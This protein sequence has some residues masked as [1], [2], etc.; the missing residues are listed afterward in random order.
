MARPVDPGRVGPQVFQG[1]ILPRVLIEHVKDQV[2]VVL[3][4]PLAGLVALDAGPLLTGTAQGGI[5]LFGESVDL[6]S[7][8]AGTKEEEVVKG[9]DGAHVEDDNV[10]GLVVLGGASALDSEV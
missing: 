9:G 7:A 3:H 2:A 1:I 5:H 8:V 4:H 10:A 6:P